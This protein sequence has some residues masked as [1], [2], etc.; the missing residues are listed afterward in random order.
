M[1][2]Q[3]ALRKQSTLPFKNV[4]E[5]HL[6]SKE[7]I[8]ILFLTCFQFKTYIGSHYKPSQGIFFFFEINICK[9]NYLGPTQNLHVIFGCYLV[10]SSNI[11]SET[12][13]IITKKTQKI[14]FIKNVKR[15]QK[16]PK[17]SKKQ[18][19]KLVIITDCGQRQKSA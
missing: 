19:F 10:T 12:N 11:M 13:N 18:Q 4:N 16:I 15:N 17:C 2:Y 5:H 14:P 7:A 9:E 3:C 8:K 1:R 6:L